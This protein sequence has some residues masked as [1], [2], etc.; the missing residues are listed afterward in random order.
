MAV[1]IN[2]IQSISPRLSIIRKMTSSGRSERIVDGYNR[3]LASIIG[4]SGLS[5]GRAGGF[6]K[7]GGKRAQLRLQ[8]PHVDQLEILTCKIR[9]VCRANGV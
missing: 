3:L 7:T 9:A 5:L 6:K 4:S 8:L 2:E 1:V